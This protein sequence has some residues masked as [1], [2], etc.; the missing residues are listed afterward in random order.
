MKVCVYVCMCVCVYVCMC[1]RERLR[2]CVKRTEKEK[3]TEI[4]RTQVEQKPDVLVTIDSKG[5]NFRLLKALAK[6]GARPRT[7]VHYVAPSV[8]A[9]KRDSTGIKRFL[10][11]HLD[12]LC[13]LFPFEVEH[14]RGHVPTACVGPSVLEVPSVRA[15]LAHRHHPLPTSTRGCDDVEAQAMSKLLILPGSRAQEV[16]NHLSI[17]LASLKIL[18]S[19]NGSGS[20]IKATVLALEATRP[21]ISPVVEAF[22]ADN[23]TIP[24][25]IT[26]VTRSSILPR[27]YSMQP[28][29]FHHRPSAFGPSTAQRTKSHKWD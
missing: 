27:L 25:E 20:T 21:L 18:S 7:V 16:K 23:P 17:M 10:A 4:C 29:F 22:V 13:V 2:V 9:Y 8:W 14:F 28:I 26:T 11:S 1:V 15:Q 12:L 5:F 24:V 6:R 19:T 3:F